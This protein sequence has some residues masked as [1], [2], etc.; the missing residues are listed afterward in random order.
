MRFHPINRRNFLITSGIL[1]GRSLF[2]FCLPGLALG[3]NKPTKFSRKKVAII[4]DDLGYSLKKGREFSEIPANLTFSILPGLPHSKDIAKEAAIKNRE[5]ILHQPMEPHDPSFDPGPGAIYKRYTHEQ[6]YE[7]LLRN[8][9]S[10]PHAT[11][12]NNHM[13][14]K[15]TESKESMVAALYPVKENRTFFIDSRTSPN[16]VA[17]YVAKR[18]NISAAYCNVFLDEVKEKDA[19]IKK[20]KFLK[21]YA[22]KYGKGIGI[23]H[24]YHVTIQAIREFLPEFSV[25]G[26]K[27][28]PASQLL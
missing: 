20:L 7:I 14:S 21:R 11:G 22:L 27:I 9:L 28:A 16:S 5:V 3:I 19:I 18:L 15:F 1:L 24:P 17:F 26:I 13:G 4:V 10:I 8:L 12:I 2:S 23:A 25:A 6:I